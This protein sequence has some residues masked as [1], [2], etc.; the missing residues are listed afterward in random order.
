[1]ELNE[2]R[3]MIT[4]LNTIHLHLLNGKHELAQARLKLML[5]Q[6]DLR[7]A[8]QHYTQASMD[9]MGKDDY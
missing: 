9:T 2:Y 1:M 4:A 3:E 8:E 5:A 7:E 6:F